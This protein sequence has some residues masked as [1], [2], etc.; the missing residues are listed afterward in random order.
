VQHPSRQKGALSTKA[1]QGDSGAANY[2]PELVTPKTK[3]TSPNTA[4]PN[5][6]TPTTATPN[7]AS[8]HENG[9]N[10]LPQFPPDLEDGNEAQL[11]TKEV[12]ISLP[13]S[14][15]GTDVEDVDVESGSAA[16]D[17]SGS[18]GQFP[19]PSKP[20]AVFPN[21]PATE[22]SVM[23]EFGE[24]VDTDGNMVNIAELLPGTSKRLEEGEGV[25]HTDAQVE[26]G[27]RSMFSCAAPCATAPATL[28]SPC[29]TMAPA[30]A[31]TV[32]ASAGDAASDAASD[33]E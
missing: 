6:T 33:L 14:G 17:T 13:E 1:R 30:S 32:I 21:L 8:T 28:C 31:V 26:G 7:A 23:N 9:R 15:D 10:P 22:E 11:G 25:I 20:L 12:E 29:A 19:A 5:T 27:F 3:T 16:V 2:A 18:A 4:T 24:F